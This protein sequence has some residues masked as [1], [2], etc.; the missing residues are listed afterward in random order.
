[1]QPG[2]NHTRKLQSPYARM[3]KRNALCTQLL[4]QHVEH[5]LG[6]V[7]WLSARCLFGSD[8]ALAWIVTVLN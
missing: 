3:S 6:E 7:D 8:V 4:K 5:V 1:M 2:A